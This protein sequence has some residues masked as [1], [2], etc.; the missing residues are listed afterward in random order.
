MNPN[1][2]DV[3]LISIRNPFVGIEINYL[4]FA[5][6]AFFLFIYLEYKLSKV[7]KRGDLY[8]FE[9]SISNVSIGIAERLLD[10]FVAASFYAVF[11]WVYENYALFNIS[12]AWW[13]WV[14][15]I[16]ATDLV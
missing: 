10:L 5:I 16:L 13:V 15:I 11:A 6:P 1:L 12:N 7:L 8:K 9:S 3:N 2:S 4:A 14:I